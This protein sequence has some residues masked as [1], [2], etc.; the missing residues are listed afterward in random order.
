MKVK[1][2]IEQLNTMSPEGDVFLAIYEAN[3]SGNQ[4]HYSAF[5][6]VQYV[7]KDGVHVQIKG[8]Y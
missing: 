7:D 5:D 3:D 8:E 1:E 4:D 6:V 2:L